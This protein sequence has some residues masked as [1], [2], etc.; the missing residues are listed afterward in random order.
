ME[1]QDDIDPAV[2]EYRRS[3]VA[4]RELPSEL[5][6]KPLLKWPAEVAALTSVP[7]RLLV[8]REQAGDAPRLVRIGRQKFARPRDIHDW[9]DAHAEPGL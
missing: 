8:K 9:I 6:H 5:V 4:R 1:L 7:E 2:A 3:A